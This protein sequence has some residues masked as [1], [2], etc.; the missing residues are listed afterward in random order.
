MLNIIAI[1]FVFS[2]LVII[3]ELGH[4]LAAKWMGVR[5]EKFSIGFPPT[6][7]CKKIGETK[8]CLSAIP[9]GGFVKMSGF[10]DE[11]MDTNVTGAEYEFNSKPVWRR[12]IIIVAGVVMN[13]I[14]AVAVLSIINFSE[15]EKII[16][17]TT[18]GV[19]G[20]DGVAEKVGFQ[21]Y[22]KIIS[23][24]N[25]PVNNWGDVQISFFDNLNNEIIFNVVRNDEQVRLIYKK[26]WLK[27]KKGEQLDIGPLIT[28]KVGDVK[29]SMPA[30][31]L[32]LQRGDEIISIAGAPVD[33]W[34]EMTEVI[35]AYPEQQISIKW[36]RGSEVLSGTITPQK[37]EEKNKEEQIEEVGKIGIGYFYEHKEIGLLKSIQNGFVNTYD[38]IVLNMRGLWWVISRTKSVE[39]IIGGPI[40]IAQMVGDAAHA[41]WA[42]YWYLIAALSSVLA[43]IN[44]LPIP[45]LD[46]GH[47]LFLIFEGIMGKPLP[48]KTRI[49][50]QQIGM[51]LLLTFIVFILYVDIKRLFS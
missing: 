5:V 1:I 21:K 29:G 24:N 38:L 46:G 31:E 11:S 26:E 40:M 37:F 33:D 12:I 9:L 10:I 27:T 17:T 4:F 30:G 25:D 22:D 51:A 44:I 19:V 6:I 50:V 13:L 3:H 23:I 35:R 36:R 8:F 42:Y 34:L 28:T 7:F 20:E 49:K 39:E 45:A 41:G 15:G 43:F 48:V 47:L 18:I 14:L 2:L 16:P 32:G